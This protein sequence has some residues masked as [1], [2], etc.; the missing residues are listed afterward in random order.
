MSAG[1]VVYR[2]S[3]DLIEIVLVARPRQQLWALPKGTPEAGETVEQT[4]IREVNEETGLEVRIQRE[5]GSISYWYAATDDRGPVRKTVHHYLMEPT[6]G[7]LEL[8]D[9]EYDV[10]G[11]LDIHEA[12]ARMSYQNERHIVEQAGALIRDLAI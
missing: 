9:H 2:R 7:D 3:G 8:H 1:G 6:G 12:L 11:W 5:I 4:A 10:V